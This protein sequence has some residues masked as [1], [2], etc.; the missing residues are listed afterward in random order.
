MKHTP[1]YRVRRLKPGLWLI[2]RTDP[3]HGRH[4][5]LAQAGSQPTALKVIDMSERG[6]RR[7][8]TT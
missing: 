5:P 3:T 7:R 1:R 4:V 2:S 6:R 8:A